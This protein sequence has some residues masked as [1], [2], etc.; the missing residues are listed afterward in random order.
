MTE[1]QHLRGQT[2]HGRKGEV[3]NAFNA[4]AYWL[5]EPRETPR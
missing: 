2:F 3:S 1:V 4:A 5:V